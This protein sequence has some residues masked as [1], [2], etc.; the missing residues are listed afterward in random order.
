MNWLRAGLSAAV[1][2]SFAT[3]ARAAVDLVTNGGFEQTTLS[4]SHQFTTQVTGWTTNGYNFLF[5]PGTATTSGAQGDYGSLSLW[6]GNGFQDPSPAGG[7]FVA[8]DGAFNTDAISQTIH[9]LTAGKKYDV[10]FDWAGAQQAGFNGPTTEQWSVSLGGETHDTPVINNPSHGFTGWFHQTIAFTA[11]DA[12]E[13]LS[14][15]AKGTPS[16]VPPFALLDGVS[17]QAVPEPSSLILGA[18]LAAL[19]GVRRLRARAARKAPA[20]S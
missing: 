20:E 15:L 2:L 13:T 16:G 12:N 18:G 8:A 6:G 10:S 11:A 9:G 14:F 3:S 17:M 4:G 7:N 5:F 1:L 19:A